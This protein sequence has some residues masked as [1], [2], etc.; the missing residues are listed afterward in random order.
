[1]L[2]FKVFKN[3]KEGLLWEK[4][5]IAQISVAHLTYGGVVVS[6]LKATRDFS[7]KAKL[8]GGLIL[9]SCKLI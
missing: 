6:T 8:R 5:N 9:T 7:A 2:S 1:M 3:T 4:L